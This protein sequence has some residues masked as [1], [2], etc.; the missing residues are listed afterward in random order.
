MTTQAGL[1]TILVV[2][3]A[4]SSSGCAS[5]DFSKPIPWG[6]GENGELEKPM[7]VVA[8]WTDTVLTANNHPPIR[9]FGGRLMFFGSDEKPAQAKGTLSIFAFREDGRE[10]ANVVPDRKY[11]FTPE[12]V[13][14][15]YSKGNLGHSYSFWL[16]WDE[17]NGGEE[18]KISLVCR[19]NAESGA[20]VMSEQTTHVLPGKKPQ[21]PVAASGADPAAT[22]GNVSSLAVQHA[23]Y[24]D[25]RGLEPAPRHAEASAAP[26]ANAPQ[27]TL[28]QSPAPAQ[29]SANPPRMTTTTI[30]L[31]ARL[32]NR[33]PTATARPNPTENVPAW[34]Q[35]GGIFTSGAMQPQ[36]NAGGPRQ[37]TATGS[38][39]SSA[40]P[41][42]KHS[43]S[44]AHS[45]LVRS[46]P[47]GGPI[48]PLP[49][50]H[51]MRPLHPVGWP[52]DSPQ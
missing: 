30:E 4:A 33:T 27:G 14:K 20:M 37:A 15:H 7:K 49:R 39:D 17:M 42:A 12:Q 25:F 47:L 5:W 8:M 6:S 26:T 16:P 23:A 9:G 22:A 51:A 2:A 34:N 18:V 50:D 11:V 29:Q 41:Q 36:A 10:I 19:F 35:P 13:A 31:P 43:L 38:A 28:E 45:A 48:F 21:H 3:L 52:S 40:A 44:S 1:A 32:G 46:R 24:N